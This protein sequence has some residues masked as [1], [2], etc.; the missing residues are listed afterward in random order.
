MGEETTDALANFIRDPT[1]SHHGV[2]GGW[3]P[4]RV[5]LGRESAAKRGCRREGSTLRGRVLLQGEVGTCRGVSRAFQEKSLSG[6]EE[7]DGTRTHAEGEYAD[8]AV[9]HD[10]RQPLGLSRDDRFQEC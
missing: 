8:A 7:R 6:A 9:S 1:A 2:C 4:L 10:R 5:D 3:H